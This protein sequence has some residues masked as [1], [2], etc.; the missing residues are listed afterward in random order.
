MKIKI[1]QRDIDE[2]QENMPPGVNPLESEFN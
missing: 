2:A 1:L